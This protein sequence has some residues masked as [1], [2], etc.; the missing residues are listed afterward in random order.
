VIPR[1]PQTPDWPE[2]RALDSAIVTDKVLWPA[3]TQADL[4]PLLARFLEKA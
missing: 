2:H 3:Q 4:M 1:I